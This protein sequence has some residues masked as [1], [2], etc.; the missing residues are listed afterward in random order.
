VAVVAVA[1]EFNDSMLVEDLALAVEVAV[2]GRRASLSV[3]IT[4]P[5]MGRLLRW[6]AARM[7]AMLA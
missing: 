7:R 1:A 5:A 2:V 3:D 4:I 6:A